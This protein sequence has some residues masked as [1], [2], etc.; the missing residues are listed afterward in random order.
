[1]MMMS[2][3]TKQILTSFVKEA[4]KNIVPKLMLVKKWLKPLVRIISYWMEVILFQIWYNSIWRL[5][6]YFMNKI[7][8]KKYPIYFSN[9]FRVVRRCSKKNSKKPNNVHEPSTKIPRTD[10]WTNPL[11]RCVCERGSSTANGVE[12]GSSTGKNAA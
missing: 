5:E 6:N 3:A 8:M 10:I 12:R 7:K 4:I 1:M 9:I 11:P 2:V